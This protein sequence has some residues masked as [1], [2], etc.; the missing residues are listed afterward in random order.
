MD[1]QSTSARMCKRSIP[2]GSVARRAGKMSVQAGIWNFDETPIQ[3][4]LLESFSRL[5]A[6]Y[7]PDREATHLERFIAILFRAFHTTPESCLE[8]QPHVS[9][10]GRVFTWDGR[11]DNRDEIS[12]FLDVDTPGAGRTD[13][14]LVAAAFD[15][16]GSSCFPLLRGDWALATWSPQ[17]Q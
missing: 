13:V 5:T 2:C 3:S 8:V 15:H 9:P 7:G 16:M 11:L 17:E 10:A 4:P 12:R 14:A 6:E 1:R